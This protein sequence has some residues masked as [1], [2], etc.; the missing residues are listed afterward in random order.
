LHKERSAWPTFSVRSSSRLN[1]Q[2]GRSGFSTVAGKNWT[3]PDEYH[4]RIL[5]KPWRVFLSTIAADI[6][7]PLFNAEFFNR[8]FQQCRFAPLAWRIASV[9][10][11]ERMG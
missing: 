9:V 1:S 10:F 7:V 3:K 6:L 8:I 4:R 11:N 5:R 2:P